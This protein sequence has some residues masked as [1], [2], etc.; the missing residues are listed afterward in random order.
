MINWH[1]YSVGEHRLACPYCNKGPKDKAAGLKV[2]LNG[3][4]VFHCFRCG[5]VETTEND[6]AARQRLRSANRS[7]SVKSQR[8]AT[9][10]DWG[11]SIWSQS[12]PIGGTAAEYLRHRRCALPPHDGHLRWHPNL[13]HPSGYIGP[14][15]V[16]LI[17]NAV[18]AEPISLHRTWIVGDGKAAVNPTRMQLKGHSLKNGVIRLWPDRC[19]TNRLGIAEGIETAL[20]LAHGYEPVWSVLDA[21]HMANLPVL[22]GIEELMIAQ[23]NDRAGRDAAQRCAARWVSKTCRVFV[24][25]QSSNDLND[26]LGVAA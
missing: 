5:Y 19:I 9:L 22:K 4:G 25:T 15:L 1:E 17:T 23:D 10:S 11:R 8:R 13:N 14:A 24:T 18:S 12:L 3:K 16:A 21:H 7:V 6:R 20:S 26:L 2:E